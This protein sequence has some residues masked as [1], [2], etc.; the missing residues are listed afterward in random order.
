MKKF[1]AVVVCVIFLM[2]MTNIAEAAPARSGTISVRPTYTPSLGSPI[3]KRTVVGTTKPLGRGVGG[4]Y[5]A[6]GVYYGGVRY[7]SKRNQ[8][9]VSSA[10]SPQQVVQVVNTAP[11]IKSCNGITYYDKAGNITRCR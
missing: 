10:S 7:T 4:F 1:V 9:A 2:P 8:V 5:P 3:P 11:P 6:Y